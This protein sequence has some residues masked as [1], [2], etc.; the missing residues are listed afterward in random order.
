MEQKNS[1]LFPSTL[2]PSLFYFF[3]SISAIAHY[4]ILTT[5]YGLYTPDIY[6][7]KNDSSIMHLQT[8]PLP[9][10]HIADTPMTWKNW[11]QHVSWLSFWFVLVM[12]LYGFIQAFWVPL[13]LETV[14][15]AIAYY[16]ITGLAITAG[17]SPSFIS[18]IPQAQNTHCGLK[19]ITVF[20]L[21]VPT[22][23]PSP[24]ASGSRQPAGAPC[25]VPS[26]GG[27]KSTV[28][29]T[30]TRTQTRIHTPSTRVFS[31]RTLGGWC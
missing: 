26:D 11:H 12:P 5:D 8:D 20:G 21:I 15:W 4:S 23:P 10:P 25:K 16:F 17:L 30:V 24:F 28:Y 29:I 31:M 3:L 22:L 27:H 13:H 2:S 14:I 19:D 9:K 7:N 6:S 1:L 18:L